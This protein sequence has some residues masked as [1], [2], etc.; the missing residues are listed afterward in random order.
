MARQDAEP[1]RQERFTTWNPY[2]GELHKRMQDDD[3]LLSNDQLSALAIAFELAQLRTE[4]HFAGK[5]RQS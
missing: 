4:V 3:D 5:G 2:A 1:S